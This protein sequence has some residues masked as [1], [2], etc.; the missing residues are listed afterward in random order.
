MSTADLRW[1]RKAEHWGEWERFDEAPEDLDPRM[2][3]HGRTSTGT[4]ER[5]SIWL[6]KSTGSPEARFYAVGKGQVGPR[7]RHVLAAVCWAYGNGY[8][9]VCDPGEI[10]LQVAA[11]E[12]VLSGGAPVGPIR[13]GATA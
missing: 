5:E 2:V 4:G 6:L 9:A 12:E 13:E 11:R 7:H 1:L 8:L 10:G 3:A